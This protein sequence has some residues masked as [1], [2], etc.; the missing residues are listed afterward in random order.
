MDLCAIKTSNM[1]DDFVVAV[2]RAQIHISSRLGE[3]FVP[4]TYKQ[5]C[6]SNANGA[7]RIHKLVP[8][9]RTHL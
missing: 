7:F 3:K 6:Y 9:E 1:S 5:I 8:V 2:L 4:Q